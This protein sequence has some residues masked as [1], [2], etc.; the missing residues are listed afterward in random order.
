MCGQKWGGGGLDPPGLPPHWI[1]PRYVI[2]QCGCHAGQWVFRC[3]RRHLDYCHPAWQLVVEVH[4]SQRTG[5]HMALVVITARDHY[6]H[7]K[8]IAE[9]TYVIIMSH[10]P[11]TVADPGCIHSYWKTQ[12]G[13]WVWWE[14][15]FMCQFHIN[16]HTNN[17]LLINPLGIGIS[18]LSSTNVD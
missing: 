2:G 3:P 6:M 7:I 1:C 17:W 16:L 11:M 18:W 9:G 10:A 4:L 12:S 15:V 14:S 8:A 13:N 5:M